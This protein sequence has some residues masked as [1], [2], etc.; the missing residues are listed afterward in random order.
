MIAWQLLVAQEGTSPSFFVPVLP[1]YDNYCCRGIEGSGNSI[2][3]LTEMM[4]N[5]RT[6]ITTI[7]VVSIFWLLA[8]PSLADA[9]TLREQLRE[10]I[11][12]TLAERSADR[13]T[14]RPSSARH[15][16]DD[17]DH[18]PRVAESIFKDGAN[19]L[20]IGHSFFVPVAR[21][22]D[23]IATKSGFSSHQV[24][25]V[26]SPGPSGTAGAIWN[27]LG[28]RKQIEDKLATGKIELLAM[29]VGNAKN[30]LEDY[31][32]WI[33][34]ALKYNPKTRFF[35]GHCWTPGGPR[36]DTSAYDNLIEES[37]TRQ[38]DAVAQLRK[39]YPD[40]HIYFINYGKTASIMKAMFEAG[41]LHDIEELVGRNRRSLFLDGLMGHGGP[42]M[43]ELSGLCWLN[44]LYGAEIDNLKH[45]DYKSD[46]EGITATVIKFNQKYQ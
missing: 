18:S 34:L 32:R 8:A 31:Q 46:V 28:Q 22:F 10:R 12:D 42:M 37:G 23:A 6:G 17:A 29:T 7:T 13:P 16:S 25:V 33:D 30:A 9:Q 35:I 4:C 43:L 20:F 44:T 1:L 45:S 27:N 14:E 21:S 38:F 5:M 39:A 24:D 3:K 26:F 15:P 36:M 40:N 11:R 2:G 19:C 41:E